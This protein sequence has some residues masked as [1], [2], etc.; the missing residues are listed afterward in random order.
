MVIDLS[1]TLRK[2][3]AQGNDLKI[4]GSQ[5]N[6]I[7][8]IENSMHQFNKGETGGKN[9]YGFSKEVAESLAREHRLSRDEQSSLQ[10]EI[11]Y[12]LRDL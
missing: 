9:R 6:R 8:D 3:S 4:Y 2:V 5:S 12:E 7:R 11:E 1:G 10:K